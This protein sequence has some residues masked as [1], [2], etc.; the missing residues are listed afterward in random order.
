MS[1]PKLYSFA[2]TSLA[3]AACLAVLAVVQRLQDNDSAAATRGLA[4]TFS[5]KAFAAGSSSQ[6]PVMRIR[7][8]REGQATS[9]TVTVRN[10]GP[11]T[12]YFWLSPGRVSDRIGAGGGKL[13][14]AMALTVLD[15]TD[16]DSPAVVYRG[17]LAQV[18]ARPLGFLDPGARRSFSFVAERPAGGR[19]PAA[20]SVDP[21]RGAGATIAWTWHSL[22][23][24]PAPAQP[25]TPIRRKRDAPPA[26]A[27][28]S[29]C[30]AASSCCKRR[31]LA[32]TVRCNEDCATRPRASMARRADCELEDPPE[33][34]RDPAPPRHVGPL[35]PRPG[36]SAAKR[37]AGRAADQGAPERRGLRPFRQPPPRQPR[38]HAASAQLAAYPAPR[39]SGPR[40]SAD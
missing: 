22:A 9:G 25:L 15:V 7:G 10:P 26:R 38:H 16:I 3:V 20:P 33:R 2:R 32:L 37:H 17:P 18:G 31:A 29:R 34:A 12:R 35:L 39:S 28:A 5:G 30:P 14:S 1:R 36:G 24:T 11:G 40:E 6:A 23:G 19:S 27:G 21:Y 4:T 8:L 13:S